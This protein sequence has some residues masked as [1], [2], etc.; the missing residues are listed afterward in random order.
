MFGFQS[1]YTLD[2]ESPILFGQRLDKIPAKSPVAREL[3][4]LAVHDKAL[5]TNGSA[6]HFEH[7]AQAI[8]TAETA[9][10]KR[11]PRNRHPSVA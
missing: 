11:C 6:D 4:E 8:V 5:I 2:R 9:F 1:I 7:A 3:S 10:V